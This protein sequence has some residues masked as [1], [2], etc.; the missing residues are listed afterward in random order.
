MNFAKAIGIAIIVA[1]AAALVVA[2][3]K[4]QSPSAAPTTNAPVGSI[5]EMPPQ[6]WTA[7]GGTQGQWTAMREHCRVVFSEVAAIQKMSPDQ[8]KAL[9]P[10]PASDWESCRR[11]SGSFSGAAQASAAGGPAPAPSGATPP[12]PMPTPLPPELPVGPQSLEPDTSDPPA[13][14][15]ARGA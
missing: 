8:I 14:A 13:A 1:S 11:I 6:Y 4:A 5:P 3:A 9:T 12:T 15:Q 2:S 10:V 7:D